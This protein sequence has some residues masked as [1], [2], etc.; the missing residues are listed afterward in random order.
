MSLASLPKE[1]IDHPECVE[2][3]KGRM[4][5]TELASPEER[6]A[7]SKFYSDIKKL[8]AYMTVD[9]TED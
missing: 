6:K 5:P 2:W 3:I 4:V 1:V 7:I 8:D 9:D